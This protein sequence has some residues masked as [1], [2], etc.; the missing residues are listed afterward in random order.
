MG[1]FR[2]LFD[3][4]KLC[5]PIIHNFQEAEVLNAHK[6]VVEVKEAL[7]NII[8]IS[9]SVLDK[10]NE[11]T[12]QLENQFGNVSEVNVVDNAVEHDP[13][14]RT[15]IISDNQHQHVLM[16]G[17]H[18]PKLNLYPRTEKYSFK[19]SWFEKFSHLEYS[20]VKDAAFCYVCCLFPRGAGRE[21]NVNNWTVI[22]VK[23][24][25]KMKGSNGS[26]IVGKLQ[27][28]FRSETHK[29]ALYEFCH[30]MKKNNHIDVMLDKNKKK[31]GFKKNEI[32]FFILK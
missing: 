28:H 8:T 27:K 25:K 21:K 11:V 19:Y 17:P 13:G 1:Q 23:N 7:D 20:T 5:K 31:T 18:Q 26:K 29:A 2:Y 22:G 12:A 3:Y 9:N 4:M 14:K 30:F 24:W 32:M 15:N 6:I 10:C 16:L